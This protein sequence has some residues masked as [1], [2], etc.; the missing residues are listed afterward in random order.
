MR[1]VVALGGNALL[2]PGEPAD[3]R[4][5]RAHVRRA[6]AA[7]LPVLR[8]HE[9][10]LTHGNGPQVGLLAERAQRDGADTA[11]PLDVLGAETEGLIGYLMVQE[12][13]NA[14]PDRPAAAL[15]TQTL[16][17]VDDPA[18]GRPTK[19]VGMADASGHRRL[20]PSPE[21]RGIVELP[22]IRA[23]LAAGIVVVCT[24]GGGVPVVADGD[25][26]LTGVEGVVDKDL[27]S[28]LLALELDADGLVML[29]DVEAV[30]DGFGTPDARPLGTIDAAAADELGCAQGSMGP[31]VT[32]AARFAA[33]TGG[34]A[35]IG[36]LEDAAAIVAGQRG[37]RVVATGRTAGLSSSH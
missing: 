3:V 32:A 30:F 12:L 23:L 18:F 13:H 6:V 1:L 25:A 35:A 7:L 8:G 4:T 11:E 34:L 16:V 20:V 24:G 2:R 31:K 28:S 27:A 5:Q 22:A 9:V 29:T 21:P 15:L 19:P 33:A 37:T 36:A 17:D 26:R 10:I 14:L